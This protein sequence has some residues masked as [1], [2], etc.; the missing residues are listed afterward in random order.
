[1]L[2]VTSCSP[3]TERHL[4]HPANTPVTSCNPAIRP[5]ISR[6]P[7]GTLMSATVER[8]L[9]CL[10]L[11][12]PGQ[13]LSSSG[14]KAHAWLESAT[15][16][17]AQMAEDDRSARMSSRAPS[18]SSGGSDAIKRSQSL[19]S[20]NPDLKRRPLGGMQAAAGQRLPEQVRGGRLG[21][22]L[23]H[24]CLQSSGGAGFRLCTAPLHGSFAMNSICPSECLS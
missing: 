14:A 22:G 4:L 8:L 2:I 24:V 10:P 6:S 12:G 5:A 21:G 17:E 19:H 18:S 9:H 1:M 3:A 16:L 13:Q 15:Q 7:Q 11:Q 23:G 20:Q